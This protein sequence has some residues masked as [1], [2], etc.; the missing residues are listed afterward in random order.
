MTPR[1]EPTPTF[2]GPA[3]RPLFGWVHHAPAGAASLGLVVCNPFGYE[4]ICAHR[5]L[6]HFAQTAAAAGVPALRFDYDGTG[7][8][9]GG[10]RDPG[11]VAAW[12]ASVGAAIDALRAATGV[13]AVC[14]LGFRFGALLGALAASSR[15]DVAGFVAIAP[16]TSGKAYLRE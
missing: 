9:A 6:R 16:V 7:D 1:P 3:D 14:V 5:T 11:R 10:D 2:F 12:V 4:A 15:D 13:G 8:S